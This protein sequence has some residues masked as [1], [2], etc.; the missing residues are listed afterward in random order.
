[1]GGDA[2]KGTEGPG[3]KSWGREEYANDNTAFHP[4]P[5]QK[6]MQK[7]ENKTRTNGHLKKCQSKSLTLHSSCCSA[8]S[9][10][11]TTSHHPTFM[12]RKIWRRKTQQLLHQLLKKKKQLLAHLQVLVH[13]HP[14]TLPFFLIWVLLKLVS[15][16]ADMLMMLCD[17]ACAPWPFHHALSDRRRERETYCTSCVQNFAN[18]LVDILQHVWDSFGLGLKWP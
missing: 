15:S 4:P 1:M 13:P 5:P 18:L 16:L 6:K 10:L 9:F 11:Y 2:K 14:H 3:E 7:V 17:D 8:A 12:R